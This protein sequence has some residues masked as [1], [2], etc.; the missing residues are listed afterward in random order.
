MDAEHLIAGA[1]CA[2]LSLAVRL[3][4]RP[5][6][7]RGRILIVD[8]RTTLGGD[9][10]FCA[11]RGRPHPFASAITHRWARWKVIGAR[12]EVV[13]ALPSRPYE[14]V[15][16]RALAEAA[17][18][19]L[20]RAEGVEVRL[21]TAVHAIEDEGDWVRART[22]AGEVR[23][24][25][26][27]DARGGAPITRPSH[28]DV[29]WVQHFVGWVVRTERA[30]FDPST[31]TLMD[32]RVSQERGPHFV[33]VLPYAPDEALVEDTYFSEAPLAEAEYEATI[34]TWL[35]RAGAGGYRI[36]RRE[37]G[38]IPMETAPMAERGAPRIVP[39]GLRGG[40]AKPSTG[41]AFSFI[42]RHA[43]ALAKVARDGVRPPP[44]VA[45][46]SRVATFFDRVF[47]SYLRRH[48]RAAPEVFGALF[49]RTPPAALVR[50]LSEEGGVRDH[51][52]VMNGVPRLAVALEAV[53]SRKLW[54]RA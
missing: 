1:G 35:E 29:R 28:D 10:I 2:G 5:V 6:A 21:G 4:S 38:A 39:I 53:R 9:R 7:E 49:A 51:L 36:L 45:V 31:A 50:F 27:W 40:A 8:P 22:D 13:R 24:R 12:G 26:A 48:P 11:W 41:Y 25:V 47:L 32:F 14:H 42:Q 37:R 34:L 3:A 43:D 15:D 23:A 18:A 17:L 19:R 44:K 30:I 33:Y 52:A 20:A 16:S 46:R 54:M